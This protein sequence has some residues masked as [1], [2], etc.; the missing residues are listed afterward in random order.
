M[1]TGGLGG[2]AIHFAH[3]YR[4]QFLVGR[5]LFIQILL[6]QSRPLVGPWKLPFINVIPDRSDPL[7]IG[8]RFGSTAHSIVTTTM[9]I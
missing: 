4:G 2:G 1:L 6:Q 7:K 5:F 3:G 8:Q 9:S